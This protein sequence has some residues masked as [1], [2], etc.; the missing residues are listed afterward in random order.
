MKQTAIVLYIFYLA[1]SVLNL[2]FLLFGKMPLF[3]AVC[4]MF[5]TAGTGGFGIVNSSM[6]EY[7]PYIQNV[8][9]VFMLL[10]GINFSCYYLII[11]KQFKNVIKDEELRLYIG[12]V[13]FSIVAIAVNIYKSIGSVEGAIRHS[14]FQVASVITTTG[15]STMDYDLWPSFSK[16]IIL[17][18]MV[19]GACAGS[20]GGGLKCARL[21]LL[22]KNLGRNI[23]QI[24]RP[25][26]VK[27]VKVNQKVID[28]KVLVNTNAYF[29]VYI[30]II[31]ISTLVLSLDGF[32]ILTNFS[33]SLACFNNIGPGFELAGPASNFS[34]F[35]SMSKIVL[36]FDML[37]GRLEI[38]PILILFNPKAWKI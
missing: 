15:Y 11:L 8:T 2:V 33:A 14:A 13:A 38:F 10:F 9:T 7:S 29:F 36:I 6:G 5:G 19:V 18:L 24:L 27:V 23:S 17:I 37:A 21:L 26:R 16:S 3:D 1:L 25:Q 30:V 22:M 35:S 12:I 34:G 32:S 31:G 20:T 28:E 4:I